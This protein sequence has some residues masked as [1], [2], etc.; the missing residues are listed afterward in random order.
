LKVDKFESLQ[1]LEGIVANMDDYGRFPL[2]AEDENGRFKSERVHGIVNLNKRHV[3]M[4]CGK[5]YPVFGHR[6]AYGLVINDL[7]ERNLQVHGRIESIGDRTKM[8]VL[9]NELKVI[10][11]DKDGVELGIYFKNPMDRKTTF[12]GNGYT[13]R[14]WCSNGAGVKTLLPQLE[15]NEQ[16]T[17][18]MLHR[19]PAVMRQFIDESLRQT[20]FLQQLVT[21]SMDTKVVFESREQMEATMFVEFGTVADKH[22]KNILATIKSLE[23][24]RWDMFNATTYY[25]SH[26]SVSM[27]V[28]DKIDDIAEKFLNVTRPINPVPM[29]RKVAPIVPLA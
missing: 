28:Q 12:K 11:D 19:L 2:Y 20:N 22:V 15:I 16:H 18:T 27:D 21:K 8:T 14:Q 5:E 23:P 1:D 25:T 17:S 6:Q 4:P 26:S 3:T 7:K 13:W 10:K 24:T 9:F 29:I